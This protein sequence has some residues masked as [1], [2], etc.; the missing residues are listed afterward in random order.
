MTASELYF[1]FFFSYFVL[2]L[3]F[4]SIFLF[5]LGLIIIVDSLTVTAKDVPI[6]FW[7]KLFYLM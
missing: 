4:I 2:I 5:F 1:L 3:I 6:Y 7:A